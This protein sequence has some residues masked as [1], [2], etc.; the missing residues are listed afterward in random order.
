MTLYM[1]EKTSSKVKDYVYRYRNVGI[2]KIAVSYLHT[3]ISADDSLQYN[4]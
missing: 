3:S 1:S 2:C 4:V